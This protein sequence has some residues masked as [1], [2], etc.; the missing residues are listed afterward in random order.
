MIKDTRSSFIYLPYK[1]NA[2]IT[3]LVSEFVQNLDK[4]KWVFVTSV[5]EL[6]KDIVES[7]A[8]LTPIRPI[9]PLVSPF[10]QLKEK[11]QPLYSLKLI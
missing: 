11:T 8:S 3:K 6:E 5:Y 7:M 9:G 4:L 10:L 2:C 1:K